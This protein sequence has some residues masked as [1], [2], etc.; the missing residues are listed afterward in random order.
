M[1]KK[2]DFRKIEY[3]Q[4]KSAV[5]IIL[6]RLRQAEITLIVRGVGVWQ[7]SPY[8]TKIFSKTFILLPVLRQQSTVFAPLLR[9]LLYNKKRMVM[10]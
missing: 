3:L 7:R 5:I 2:T 10:P 6:P 8:L 4:I 1:Q 9:G